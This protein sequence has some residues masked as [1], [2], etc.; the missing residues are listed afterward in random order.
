[1]SIVST[2]A[3]VGMAVGPPCVYLDQYFSII[4]RKDSTGFSMDVC[5][6]LVSLC[7]TTFI[8]IF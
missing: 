6:V 2:L 3:S 5:G 7:G 8:E 4:R 1:M